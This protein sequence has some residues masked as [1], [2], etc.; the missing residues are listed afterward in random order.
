VVLAD[1]RGKVL[2][3]KEAS[4]EKSVFVTFVTTKVIGPRG[5]SGI[6]LVL[7]KLLCS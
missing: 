6:K 4:K 3:G 2:C 7:K 1:L 5:H